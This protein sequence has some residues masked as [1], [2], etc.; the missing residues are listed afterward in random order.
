LSFQRDCQLDL[1]REEGV[2]GGEEVVS[3]FSR[4]KA[5]G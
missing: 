5:I 1:G 2:G 4:K 3:R